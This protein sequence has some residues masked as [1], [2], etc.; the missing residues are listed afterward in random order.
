MIE[1]KRL[2]LKLSSLEDGTMDIEVS[3]TD[4]LAIDGGPSV[5]TIP[6]PWEL[7]GAHCIGADE[8]QLIDA[9]VD[10]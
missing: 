1:R 6:L 9:V 7:P 10:A 3:I 5:R 8:R 4:A 2:A